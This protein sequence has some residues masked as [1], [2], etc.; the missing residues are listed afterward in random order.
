M[1]LMQHVLNN[2]PE[3]TQR[4]GETLYRW[5]DTLAVVIRNNGEIGQF[6]TTLAIKRDDVTKAIAAIHSEK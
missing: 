5:G 4:E 2:A 3:T 6:A 1:E